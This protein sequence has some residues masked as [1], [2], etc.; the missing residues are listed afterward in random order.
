MIT[1]VKLVE[2]RSSQETEALVIQ[3]RALTKEYGIKTLKL[4][5]LLKL[6]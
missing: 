4:A 1:A 3:Y 5:S 6:T 2:P